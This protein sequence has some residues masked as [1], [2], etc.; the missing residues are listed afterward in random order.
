VNQE[1]ITHLNNPYMQWHWSSN[2]ESP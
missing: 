2:K 1:D